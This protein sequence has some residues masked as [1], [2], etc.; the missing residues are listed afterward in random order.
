MKFSNPM[1]SLQLRSDQNKYDVLICGIC[2]QRLQE[3]KFLRIG[4]RNAELHF[5]CKRK[6][7]QIY[8]DFVIG[9]NT[10]MKLKFDDSL[11]QE[12][13]IEEYKPQTINKV[14]FKIRMS[15][16]MISQTSFGFN[17]SDL[18]DETEVNDM[19]WKAT[20]EQIMEVG[21]DSEKKSAL[22]LEFDENLLQELISG[23]YH[24]EDWEAA[25]R[26][27]FFNNDI[28]DERELGTKSRNHRELKSKSEQDSYQD[29]E[30]TDDK[31]SIEV[32]D[33]FEI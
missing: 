3:T 12:E 29:G 16:T 17:F 5:Q 24:D 30:T 2:S 26:I 10:D 8:E 21:M 23:L 22:T 20:K 28:S 32:D 9:L 7:E 6:E 33:L 19:S 1:F 14:Q 18:F 13:K 11:N 4:I 31:M 25:I 15:S 27:S